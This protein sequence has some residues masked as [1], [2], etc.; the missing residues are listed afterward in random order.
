MMNANSHIRVFATIR[1]EAF[2]NYESDVKSNL[3]G[4]TTRLSGWGLSHAPHQE[5]VELVIMLS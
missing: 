4:A 1:E 2:V 5:N 3:F